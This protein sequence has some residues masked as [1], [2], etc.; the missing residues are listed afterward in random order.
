MDLLKSDGYTKLCSTDVTLKDLLLLSPI[1]DSNPDP[2]HRLKYLLTHRQNVI[3]EKRKDLIVLDRECSRDSN[4]VE[5]LKFLIKYPI[6]LTLI[7]LG[8]KLVQP[9]RDIFKDT[10]HENTFK[11]F[12]DEYGKYLEAFSMR[13]HDTPEGRMILDNP[14]A[15]CISPKLRVFYFLLDAELCQINY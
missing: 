7:G 15:L 9:P 3:S 4:Y 10:Y 8:L 14:W 2:E 1:S 6:A 13:L 5:Y 12:I 11:P